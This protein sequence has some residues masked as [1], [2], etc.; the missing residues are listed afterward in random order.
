MCEEKFVSGVENDRRGMGEWGSGVEM[1]LR[2]GGGGGRDGSET[3]SVTNMKEN[4]SL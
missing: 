4:K 1:G 3:G 2:R